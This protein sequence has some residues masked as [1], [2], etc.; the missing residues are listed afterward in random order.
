[1][2]PEVVSR[3]TLAQLFAGERVQ[4]ERFIDEGLW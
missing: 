4:W 3:A 1:M 2:A